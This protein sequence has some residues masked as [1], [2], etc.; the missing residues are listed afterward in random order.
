MIV[1]KSSI[2]PASREEIFARLQRLETLQYI[3][4]PYA[5]FTPVED[6]IPDEIDSAGKANLLLDR[7]AKRREEG[8]TTPKQIR[9][10]ESKGFQHVGT[11]DFDAARKLIDRIAANN[12][13]VPHEI[14]PRCYVPSPVDQQ[15]AINL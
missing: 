4:A 11:W 6:N 10:L 14:E 15:M 8:L 1:R 5:T 12:W 7:L 2:F 9:F 13:R 3:A